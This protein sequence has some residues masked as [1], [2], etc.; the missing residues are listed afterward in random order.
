MFSFHNKEKKETEYAKTPRKSRNFKQIKFMSLE[1]QN[2]VYTKC[3]YI[4]GIFT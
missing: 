1:E 4:V 3:A 2:N